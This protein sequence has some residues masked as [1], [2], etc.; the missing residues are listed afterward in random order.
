[1]RC[2]CERR[3]RGCVAS[4]QGGG[5]EAG[6]TIDTGNTLAEP[7]VWIE[8]GWRAMEGKNPEKWFL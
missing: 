8:R 3:G 4:R 5:E 1:M 6:A 7:G 2:R